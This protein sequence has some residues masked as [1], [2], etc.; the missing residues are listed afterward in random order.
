V[1][2]FITTQLVPW[3]VSLHGV[4]GLHGRNTLSWYQQSHCG[5]FSEFF[6]QTAQHGCWRV[7]IECGVVGVVSA[8]QVLGEH[9]MPR[10]CA[11]R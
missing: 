3:Q 1:T 8:T 9:G 10:L 7:L 5:D 4:L 2:G 6:N 11:V